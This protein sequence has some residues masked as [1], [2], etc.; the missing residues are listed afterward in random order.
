MYTLEEIDRIVERS[1]LNMN[2]MGEPASL[3]EPIEYM[4]GIGGKR[5][6]PRLCLA[7]YSLFENN[8]STEIIY[9]A[10]SLEIFHEFTLIHDDI[11]DNADTR[12]NQ[13]TVYKKWGNN[14][15]ILSGDVMSI[16]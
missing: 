16:L 1:I 8:I 4:I 15:A 13:M 5:I 11:M 10:L 9:P 2:I 3:Y 6:R 7:T 12:R 14:V